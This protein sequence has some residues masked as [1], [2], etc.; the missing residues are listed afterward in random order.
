VR[1][2]KYP[3]C[4]GLVVNRGGLVAREGVIYLEVG[5]YPY[6]ED[7]EVSFKLIS[8]SEAEQEYKASQVEVFEYPGGKPYPGEGYSKNGWAMPPRW[9]YVDPN[10]G[11]PKLFLPVTKEYIKLTF[12]SWVQLAHIDVVK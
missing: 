4:T 10:D 5:E 11:R 9:A 2:D 1:V 6:C 3:H 12:P 7:I 8:R